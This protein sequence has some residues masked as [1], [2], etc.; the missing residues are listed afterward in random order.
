MDWTFTIDGLNTVEITGNNV[1]GAITFSPPLTSN[2]GTRNA[3]LR[4]TLTNYPTIFVDNPFQVVTVCAPAFTRTS[5]PESPVEIILNPVSTTFTT[6]A[7]LQF[8]D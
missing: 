5:Q 3:N 4:A 8:T 7:A 1:L 2:P 6:T